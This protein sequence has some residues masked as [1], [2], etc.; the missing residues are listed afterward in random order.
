MPVPA[1]LEDTHTLVDA[2]A[3]VPRREGRG[4]RFIGADRSEHFHD[5][6]SLWEEAR[7]R[8]AHLVQRYGLRKGDRLALIIPDNREFVLTFFG[9]MV[10]GVV[11]VPIFPRATF[12]AV[13]GYVDVLAHVIAASGSRVAVCMDANRPILTKLEER[14]DVSLEA[15]ITTE[16]AFDGQAPATPVAQAAPEDLCFLQFTSGSTSKPK[17]VM[18]THANVMANTKAFLGPD[19]IDRRDEDVALAWLPLFHD[20]GL[21]GFVLGTLGHDINT[22]LFPTPTFARMPRLWLELLSQHRASITY[23]PNFGYQLAVKRVREQDLETLDLSRMR[24]AGCGAEPIRAKTLQEFGQRLERTGFDARAFLPS[25]GMAESTLAITFHPRG[26]PMIVDRVDADAMKAGRAKAVSGAPDDPSILEIVSCGVPFPGHG[27]RVVGD[28]GRDLGERE[29]GE[30][31]IQ[32]P[33]VTQGYFQNPEA[34]EAAFSDGWLKT[35]DLGYLADGNLYV[36]GRVKD[37]IIINGANHYPQ[38]LEWAAGELEGV[39]RGNVVAFSVM[40]DG[41]EQ[42]IV[43]AEGNSSDAPGLRKTIAQCIA[44]NF[45]LQPAHVAVVRLGT[46]PKTSSGK[47]QRAKTKQMYEDGALEE[48]P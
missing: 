41:T 16:T 33:S 8:G 34:T 2:F 47:A 10:V 26:T 12:K 37:L 18:V 7:R 39:R 31:L 20:M 35:G 24:I 11:P 5:H 32:G 28:G 6:A 36:C 45:G 27:L 23:A 38:D 30:I 25:Y 3:R 46:L 43:A 22:V 9:A 17:G 4:F 42:L 48:H 13:E 15:V 19:G 44:E 14:P 40:R 29:V 21:I 1:Y